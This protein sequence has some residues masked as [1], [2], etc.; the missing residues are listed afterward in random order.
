MYEKKEETKK[1]VSFFIR[2]IFNLLGKDDGGGIRLG[3]SKSGRAIK[4]PGNQWTEN[5]S[6]PRKTSPKL[7]L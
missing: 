5:S 1:E 4:I 3:D 6:C 2:L 7:F